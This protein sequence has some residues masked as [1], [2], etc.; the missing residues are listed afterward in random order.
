M[1]PKHAETRWTQ[2]MLDL[3]IR[4]RFYSLKIW[5]IHLKWV[6][7]LKGLL[8]TEHK[9]ETHRNKSC[10]ARRDFLLDKTWFDNYFS[11]FFNIFHIIIDSMFCKHIFPPIYWSCWCLQFSKENLWRRMS[12]GKEPAD[13]R[14]LQARAKSEDVGYKCCIIYPLVN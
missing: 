13:D 2:W 7:I 10:G 9:T 6:C 11:I 4:M 5:C 1:W 8:L 14:T 3:C 12:R